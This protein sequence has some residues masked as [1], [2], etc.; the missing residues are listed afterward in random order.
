MLAYQPAT[1]CKWGKE[2][3]IA[4][5]PKPVGV[6]VL[7]YQRYP[8]VPIWVPKGPRQNEVL[9]FAEQNVQASREV[10]NTETVA[11]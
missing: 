3:A 10:T 8:K 2:S 6:C 1:S 9:M 11:S 4:A 7:P 5:W